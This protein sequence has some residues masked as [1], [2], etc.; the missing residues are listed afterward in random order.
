MEQTTS[1]DL[2]DH[3]IEDGGYDGRHFRSSQG[4]QMD[5]HE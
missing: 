4:R 3:D 5:E 2:D 1:L